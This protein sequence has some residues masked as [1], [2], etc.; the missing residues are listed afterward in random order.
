MHELIVNN[1]ADQMMAT[2]DSRVFMSV[3]NKSADAW[4]M[5][6]D[7]TD[8]MK[9]LRRYVVPD[10]EIL[11]DRIISILKSIDP[12]ADHIREMQD[13]I[14]KETEGLESAIA[15]LESLLSRQLRV[16]DDTKSIIFPDFYT[17]EE[18]DGTGE[19]LIYT[20]SDL[21]LDFNEYKPISMVV[22]TRE[23]AMRNRL[24]AGLNLAAIFSQLEK[25]Y[26]RLIRCAGWDDILVN[27]KNGDV[28]VFLE[29]FVGDS[30]RRSLDPGSSPQALA[31]TEMSFYPD[32]MKH[33]LAYAL[34]RLLLADDP[35]DGAATLTEYPLLTADAVRMIHGPDAKY[36]FAKDRSNPC[37]E[38]IGSTAGRIFK[39]YP[40]FLRKTFETTFTAG[41]T[42]PGQ[43][44]GMDEWLLQMRRLR[45]CLVVVNNQIR[46]CDPGAK[47]S[48]LFLQIGVYMIPLWE[49]KAIYYYHVGLEADDPLVGDNGII[50]GL[51]KEGF[52]R[53]NS[54]GLVWTVY[55]NGIERKIHPG[56]QTQLK[57]GMFM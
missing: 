33:F 36:I 19:L 48:V 28:K 8:E 21:G 11:Q 3:A 16:I 17:V 2:I 49:K 22:E 40:G 24:M 46:L 14:S 9:L 13:R 7:V 34:F 35:F 6:C 56:E 10:R 1:D 30:Q 5:R 47:N 26:S 12:C 39:G 23:F 57:E 29:D 44:P 18:I 42:D 41:M 54:S 43:R 52:L 25:N 15:G 45:D 20:V 4:Y 55:R 38:Y 32:G 31:G 37:T 27:Q 51:Y 53:N 50:A